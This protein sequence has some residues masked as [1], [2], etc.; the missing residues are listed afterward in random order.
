M[1]LDTHVSIQKCGD[2]TER[3]SGAD[4]IP[5][6]KSTWFFLQSTTF[7]RFVLKIQ[8]AIVKYFLQFFVNIVFNY[9]CVWLLR[10]LLN[11]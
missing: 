8:S 1:L 11:K 9:C 4:R 7:K 2:C 3:S 10:C 6:N 5:K